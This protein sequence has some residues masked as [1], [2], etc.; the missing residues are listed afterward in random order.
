MM[1]MHSVSA[2]QRIRPKSDAGSCR[3]VSA[4]RYTRHL[5]LI[6][7]AQLLSQLYFQLPLSHHKNKK[8]FHFPGPQNGDAFNLEIGNLYS[9]NPN[10]RSN[11][12]SSEE[13]ISE[14][15]EKYG[16]L[17]NGPKLGENRI[18]LGFQGY[19][20]PAK[21]KYEDHA[22]VPEKQKSAPSEEHQASSVSSSEESS[23]SSSK[24]ESLSED[25]KAV[26]PVVSSSEENK[27]VA[28]VNEPSNDETN[29]AAA[30]PEVSPSEENTVAAV[31]EE[32]YSA[33]PE[34]SSG[35]DNNAPAVNEEASL[36]NPE[37]DSSSVQGNAPV[38]EGKNS[39]RQKS[40][41]PD[42]N[43][44]VKLVPASFLPFVR[45]NSLR[46]RRNVDNVRPNPA[47]RVRGLNHRPLRSLELNI[48]TS[49]SDL[50][51][52][53]HKKV[54]GPQGGIEANKQKPRIQR[55]RKFKY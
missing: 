45:A 20:K 37:E 52:E 13:P 40:S 31:N 15:P 39:S 7:S 43:Q 29:E 51:N 46:D 36:A 54:L 32:A 8:P 50:R 10:K 16:I 30:N 26:N 23:Q 14:Q 22:S 42:I 53:G 47:K 25:A 38:S 12:E 11:S 35:D 48:P 9:L 44:K 27:A 19:S 2:S 33:N 55:Q 49:V 41:V 3:Q 28:V 21:A 18:V 17:F 4:V 1:Q 5:P 6:E 34:V 24:L